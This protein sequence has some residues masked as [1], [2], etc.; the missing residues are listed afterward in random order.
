MNNITISGYINGSAE[1]VTDV[2][3]EQ[4]L[5][6]TLCSKIQHDDFLEEVKIALIYNKNI[7][8]IPY[9]ELNDGDHVYLTGSSY[10][11]SLP[12]LNGEECLSWFMVDT[13]E[14]EP[15]FN[16]NPRIVT[17]MERDLMMSTEIFAP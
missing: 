6:G 3:E 15:A 14:V 11:K 8:K 1:L 16:P 4:F 10:Q 17:P 5:I 7:A 2:N 9:W 13:I 12:Y